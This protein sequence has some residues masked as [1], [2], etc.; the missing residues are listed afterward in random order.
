MHFFA[1]ELPPSVR[2]HVDERA[3]QIDLG[4]GDT[5]GMAD[6][7]AAWRKQV[8]PHFG[9]LADRGFSA[10]DVDD[11]SFWSLWVQY[12]SDTA[13]VRVSKSNEFVRCEVNL[14]R[15]VDGAV[16]P[17]PIWITAERIDWTLLDTV[18]EV[19]A[20][21]LMR[22]RPPG[23]LKTSELDSQLR[24]WSQALR[25]WAGDFLT[26]GFDPIDEAA[27]VGRARVAANP[28]EVQVWIADSAPASSEADVAARVQAD[29]PP[30]VGVTVRRYR[31]GRGRPTDQT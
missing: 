4:W 16:P 26:G 10:V 3:I 2:G 7:A 1:S 19:R 15:L 21:E 28:Q 5:D 12:R 25:D 31:R 22:Q 9:F 13:A 29:V 27:A 18:L 17:Y 23:G 6:M 11:S 20:P 30:N 8:D 14:I 24:F